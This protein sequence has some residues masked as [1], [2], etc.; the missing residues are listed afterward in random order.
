[1]RHVSGNLVIAALVFAK[2]ACVAT[3]FGEVA[4]LGPLPENLARRA[5]IAAN[6]E[7]E[8][9]P[10]ANV[11]D[12]RITPA[13]AAQGEVG[14]WAVNGDK[15]KGQAEIS[16]RW[17]EPVV[18]AEVVYFGRCAWQLE[19]AF[20]NYVVLVDGQ[21]KPV[22]EGELK[23]NADPQRITFEPVTTTRLTLKFTS[24][25]GGSNPGAAEIMVFAAPVSGEQLARHVRFAPNSLVSDHM[26]VQRG[27]PVTVWGSAADGEKVS[28]EF[29]G[30]KRETVAE[31]GRWRVKFDAAEPGEPATIVM[32]A[33]PGRYVV[34]DVLVGE[35]W[36]ASGQSNMEMPVDVRYWPSRY[37]G[38]AN[39][40]DE[41]AAGNHPQIRM[42]YVPRVAAGALRDDS[43]GQW[44]VCSPQT[45]GGFSAVAYFFARKLNQK[46][47]VPVGMIDCSL[48]AT[49]IE[50]WTPLTGLAGVPELTEITKK[51]QAELA[52][53]E[54]AAAA[55][56]GQPPASHQ[57]Q[58]TRLYNGMV[59]RLTPLPIRGAIWY[60]GEGNVGDGM[61]YYHKMRALIDGWRGA[62][63]DPAMPFLYVQLAP[64]D[65]GKYKGSKNPFKLPALWE[66]QTAALQIPNTGMVVTT[67]ITD[68]ENIHPPNKQDVGLRLALWALANTYGQQ[69]VPHRGP[70][71][72]R[73][74]VEGGK[75]RLFFD[76]TNGGLASRD[77]QPL[78]W[79]TVAGE[80]KV[81][82]PATAAI[83]GD[84]VLV[85]CDKVVKPQA[86]RFGWHKLATPNL[87]NQAGL[88]AVPFRTDD[89]QVEIG[90]EP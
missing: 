53:Y 38:V 89:W 5:T 19:E 30:Q 77:G 57:H 67:D 70:Q 41:V 74:V 33:A 51:T 56:P 40:K 48:G 23:K 21:D 17:A 39:A 63:N 59:H 60:Q 45:V 83:D 42:F 13:G 14:S 24:S 79:F 34:R 76:H 58:P 6:S 65:Y 85:T 16:F 31:K 80:D 64:F 37:D 52:E 81:F 29:R 78:S 35:V 46:L 44:N 8:V 1:L 73:H 2:W 90:L 69:N 12:G 43:G 71:Y 10:A 25:H 82:H 84:T 7:Q 18:V 54:K 26:V 4:A 9:H 75:V 50:P 66:A 72:S 55:S 36:V 27:E 32:S 68:V 62:W 88:P 47:K 22:A 49:Y 20:K 3:A 87:A 11:A 86:V 61:L 28:V 15:A